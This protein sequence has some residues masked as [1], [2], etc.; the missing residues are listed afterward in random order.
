[1]V[2]QMLGMVMVHTHSLKI[3]IYHKSLL[4]L[5]FVFLFLARKI[6]DFTGKKISPKAVFNTLQA[7]SGEKTRFG[8][9]QS[10]FNGNKILSLSKN[11][12]GSN[13]NSCSV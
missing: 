2:F 4:G 3:W 1:M 8:M 5:N 7:A 6:F 13:P 12:N 11:A 9:I 10:I